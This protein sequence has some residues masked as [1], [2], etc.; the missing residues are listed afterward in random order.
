MTLRLGVYSDLEFWQRDGRPVAQESFL[1]F[2][3]ALRPHVDALVVAGRLAEGAGEGA[4][5]VPEDAEF[6]ALPH[7]AALSRPVAALRAVRGSLRAFGALVDR[8]DAVWLLGPHPLAVAFALQARRRGRT[9]VLGVR[10]DLPAY[11][12]T[13]HPGRP[14]LLAAGYALEGAWRLLARACPVVVVGPDL[15]RRYRRA[16]AVL[17]AVVSLVRAGDVAAAVPAR[18]RSADEPFRI[19]AVGRLD[20]EKNPLLLADVLAALV[21]RGVDARLAV[22]GTGT[23]HDAL[24]GRL[25]ELGVAGRAELLGHVSLDGALQALYRDSD[26]LLH[27]SWT[28]GVPQVLFEAFAAGLPVVATAVGG[29][30]AQVGDAA[31]VVPPGNAERAADALASLARDAALGERLAAR[32]LERVRATTLEGE[33]GRVAA[34]IAAAAG[35]G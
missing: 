15:A 12:R 33:T 26:A 23:L 10:Q 6:V 3:A 35:R 24:A 22:C 7:Y 9:V 1:L 14:D 13:R 34:F 31:V 30:P 5:A 17:P 32:G 2:A 25:A 20:P 28:E 27:V 21:A 8:V 4:Y 16:S 29:V 18:R 19:L 11:V